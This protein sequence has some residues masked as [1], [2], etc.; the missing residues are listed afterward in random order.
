MKKIIYNNLPLIISFLVL[1]FLTI[2][3]H[4]EYKSEVI[5]I[6]STYDKYIK[7][8]NSSL[9]NDEEYLNYCNSLLDEQYHPNFF[10]E[11]SYIIR[12]LNY[13]SMILFFTISMP[14][15][16]YA[17][18]CFE[19]GAIKNKLTRQTF[20][21]LKLNLLL[22]SYK[23]VLI[24]PIVI[25]IMFILSYTYT[26]TFNTFNMQ[27]IIW[28]NTTTSSPYLFII[29]YLINIIIHSILYCN[30][31]LCVVRKKH[32]YYIASILSY[33]TFIAIELILEV[34]VNAIILGKIFNINLG[35]ISSILDVLAFNDSYGII[36]PIVVST[37]M[38]L[39]SY[40]VL[41]F[42][43]KSKEKLIIDCN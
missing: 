29:V 32:N 34:G 22:E 21:K 10:S 39:L 7:E 20:K 25:I 9:S 30:I 41:Y 2:Y 28:E 17:S 38:L 16:Y 26:K 1:L 23:S 37:I 42:M 19:S 36:S 4:F 18:K 40:I 13:M 24:L 6:N 33:L 3:G 11:V 14:S 31:S 12:I 43:Y 27:D 35:A 5:G 15:I 8:C